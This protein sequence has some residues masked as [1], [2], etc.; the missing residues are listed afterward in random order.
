VLDFERDGVCILHTAP[1]LSDM[2]QLRDEFSHLDF[3]AGS[4]AF[5]LSKSAQ[6]QLSP[7]GAFGSALA[8][9]GKTGARPVRVLAFDKTPRNNW[10]LGWHQ[11]RVIAVKNRVEVAGFENWTIKNGVRHVQPPAEFMAQLF[12]LRLHLDDCDAEN[13]ALKVIPGSHR[14][15]KLLDVQVQKLAE[16]SEWKYCGTKTG[17]VVAMKTLAIHS[18]SPSQNPSHHRV[19]HVDYC[20][21][22]LPEGLE[23]ALDL[24]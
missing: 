14:L 18:S 22:E 19:L 21:A 16:T 10:N 23:W 17:E 4:R 3:R 20:E 8:K 1:E 9:L 6:R 11:D 2:L 15:G 7:Q 12:T 5:A 24:P 13:G